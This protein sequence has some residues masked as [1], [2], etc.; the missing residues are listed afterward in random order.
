MCCNRSLIL[1]FL[2]ALNVNSRAWLFKH[3]VILDSSAR[4][5]NANAS[6]LTLLH[7]RKALL[8]SI[9]HSLPSKTLLQVIIYIYIYISFTVF[10][11]EC[12]YSSITENLLLNALNYDKTHTSITDHDVNI[13]MHCRKSLLFDNDTAWVKKTNN[14]FDV[15]MGSFDGAEICE[16]IGLFLFSTLRDKFKSNDIGLYRDDGLALFKRTSG[17]QTERK[18]KEIIKHFKNHGLAITIHS[19]LHIVNFLDVTLNLTDGS[20]FPYRKPNNTTQCIDARSNHPPSILKQ[21]PSAINC[22][23]SGI[24]CNKKSFDKAKQH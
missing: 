2:D 3:L 20:Y 12:S 9:E 22:R 13:I 16:L 17:P 7:R 6:F 24:S 10:D 21:L 1:S 15:T 5:P 4:D 23:I 18:R 19:N 8:H 11:I 14:K